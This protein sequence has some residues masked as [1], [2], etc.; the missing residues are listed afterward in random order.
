M[1]LFHMI[2]NWLDYPV[3]SQVRW[4]RK[5]LHF[6]NESKQDLFNSLHGGRR[7]EAESLERRLRADYHLTT[8]YHSSRAAH[9]QEA[10]YYLH[11]LETALNASRAEL[12]GSIH[13]VDIGV[14]H[15]FYVQTL[16]SLL[17]WWH[18]KQPRTIMIDGY[19]MDAYRLYADLYSRFD[20]AA[21]HID[22]LPNVNYF[23]LEFTPGQ[24]HCHLVLSLF[25]FVTRKEHLRWGLPA[26]FFQPE[27]ICQAAY[28]SLAHGG[29]MII[30]NQG[31]GERDI[32][33]NI[34][35]S[36]GVEPFDSYRFDSPLF[37]YK[38]ARFIT[39]LKRP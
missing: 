12:P 24:D 31:S 9:Y 20:H 23:P 11:M 13:A 6:D 36:I 16:Y 14:S 25:P 37:E 18:S 21:A 39:I 10:V 38:Q 15:W 34:L 29:L 27:A 32:Q 2:R 17:L 7:A 33:L 1:S 5:G 22:T 4:S 35:R 8:Y 3:R 28:E 30:A 19:E 26:R